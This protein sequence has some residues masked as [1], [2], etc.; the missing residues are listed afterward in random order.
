MPVLT[1][2]GEQ[3]VGGMLEEAIKP[4]AQNVRGV[5]FERCGHYLFEEQPEAVSAELL[6][7]LD[8]KA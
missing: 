8:E 5:V 3:S 2:A 7:F 4:L 1:L 6:R